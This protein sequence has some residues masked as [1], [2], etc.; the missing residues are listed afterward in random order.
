MDDSSD[1]RQL[2]NWISIANI[3]QLCIV[4]TRWSSIEQLLQ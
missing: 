1:V 2:L 4:P 3:D